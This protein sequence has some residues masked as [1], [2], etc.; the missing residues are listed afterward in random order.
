[1]FPSFPDIT[2][3]HARAMTFEPRFPL[4]S[5]GLGKIAPDRD[6]RRAED[7]HGQPGPD[8]TSRS[9]TLFFKTF[10]FKDPGQGRQ[11]ETRPIRRLMGPG[12]M[13]RRS[14]ARCSGSSTSTSGTRPDTE[15]TLLNIREPKERT[16]VVV[17]HGQH[18][19]AGAARHSLSD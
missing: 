11:V 2:K 5:N 4:W 1:M 8:G 17:G 12:T 9:G 19:A 3:V 6:A 13:E 7:Q 18:D 15:A 10:S 16:D 14:P